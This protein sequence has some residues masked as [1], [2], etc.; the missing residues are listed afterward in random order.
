[1]NPR[2][3]IVD[4]SWSL[5]RRFLAWFR[6]VFAPEIGLNWPAASSRYAPLNPMAAE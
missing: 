1:M 6:V 5:S 3:E 2:E 4:I